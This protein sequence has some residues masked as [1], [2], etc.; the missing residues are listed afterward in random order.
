MNSPRWPL[1]GPKLLILVSSS[2]PTS[3][4][5]PRW[6]SLGL[7]PCQSENEAFQQCIKWRQSQNGDSWTS[8]SSPDRTGPASLCSS[9]GP[10]GLLYSAGATWGSRRLRLRLCL[11][12]DAFHVPHISLPFISAPPLCRFEGGVQSASRISL[13]LVLVQI[14]ILKKKA[15]GNS[16]KSASAKTSRGSG[17]DGGVQRCSCGT[18]ASPWL[19]TL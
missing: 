8:P 5:P 1:S 16:T 19:C 12:L 18:D 13:Q 6:S 2:V 4:R 7:C 3:D 10:N 17:R 9:S 11:P 15:G 14:Q